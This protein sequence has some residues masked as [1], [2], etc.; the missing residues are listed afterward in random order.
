MYYRGQNTLVVNVTLMILNCKASF[1]MVNLIFYYCQNYFNLPLSYGWGKSQLRRQG[2]KAKD[3][4]CRGLDNLS[5]ANK[6]ILCLSKT[7]SAIFL[8]RII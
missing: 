3:Q 5:E 2:S 6:T 8:T 1:R 4:H 7:E